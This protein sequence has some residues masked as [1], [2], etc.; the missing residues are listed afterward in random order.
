MEFVELFPVV[1]PEGLQDASFLFLPQLRSHG[2]VVNF[3][4]FAHTGAPAAIDFFED[5][6]NMRVLERTLRVATL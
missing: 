6:L 2:V 4:E 5:I 3:L 1:L